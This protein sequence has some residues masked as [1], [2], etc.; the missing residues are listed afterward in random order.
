MIYGDQF[1][2]YN[3]HNLQHL[4]EECK[5]L[6]FLDMFCCFPFENH[7]GNMEIRSSPPVMTTKKNKSLI[8]LLGEHSNGPMINGDSN[9]SSRKLDNSKYVM[10]TSFG[11]VLDEKLAK[12]QAFSFQDL[13]RLSRIL[14]HSLEAV[15]AVSADTQSRKAVVEKFFNKYPQVLAQGTDPDAF[16]M[17]M[18]EKIGNCLSRQRR[19]AGKQMSTKGG[20]PPKLKDPLVILR[21]GNKNGSGKDWPLNGDKVSYDANIKKLFELKEELDLILGE[22]AGRRIQER[23]LQAVPGIIK[24]AFET[25]SKNVKAILS[26]YS[27]VDQLENFE[28]MSCAAMELLP[29]LIPGKRKSAAASKYLLEVCQASCLP[30]DSSDLTAV[31]RDLERPSPFLIQ[32][33]TTY[34]LVVDG[35]PLISLSA[36]TS[37]SMD[38][39]LTLI[40]AYYVFD[41]HWCQ[42]IA[43]AYLFI[44]HYLMERE[45]EESKK[46]SS[47]VVFLNLLKAAM[48]NGRKGSDSE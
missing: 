44:Q 30:I 43:P 22:N 8:K 35:Q 27:S 26:K 23:W 38:A 46:C 10:P 40:A 21:P 24:V 4:G 5:R 12:R 31:I 17:L 48:A 39:L 7:I 47:L 14:T 34:H 13:S 28:H 42:D 18:V 19:S 33:G 37:S 20:R 2:T 32:C 11:L 36:N 29:F 9:L 41:I 25:N 45:Y 15:G 6:G 3:V 1:V 16:M